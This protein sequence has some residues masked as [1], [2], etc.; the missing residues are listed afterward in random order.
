MPSRLSSRRVIGGV[1]LLAAV[2]ITGGTLAA[3]KV[4]A[5]LPP[6]PVAVEAPAPE[7]EPTPEPV[8][9]APPWSA[10]S[11]VGTGYVALRSV[12]ALAE[13]RGE[14]ALVFVTTDGTVQ[15][16]HAGKAYKV[17]SIGSKSAKSAGA[18]L[19]VGPSGEVV[20]AWRV[21]TSV[22]ASTSADL[23]T[24]S[25]PVVVGTT[26]E[27]GSFHSA[28]WDNGG[29]YVAWVNAA[30]EAAS[31]AMDAPGQAVVARLTGGKWTTST[32]APTVAVV[33]VDK[34]T[35]TYR[36]PKVSGQKFDHV[37]ISAPDGSG[38]IDLGEGYDPAVAVDGDVVAVGYH[39]GGAAWLATSK[40]G[41]KTWERT[42]LDPL[43]QFVDPFIAGG[44]AGA[45][46]ISFPDATA[47]A[48]PRDSSRHR[49]GTWFD[50]K[51][52]HLNGGAEGTTGGQSA[53]IG[54]MP[55]AVYSVAASGDVF[56][57]R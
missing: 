24:W 43:G 23:V 56:V 26:G 8:V 36:T 55:A 48:S 20:V 17:A 38:A 57:V 29:P 4:T 39:I 40:D 32:L 28:A 46:W 44:K 25:A 51:G 7:P 19:A 9:V 42:Q 11:A 54:G 22:Y 37:W 34:G 21:G 53:A 50:G 30:K 31:G 27:G 10:S 6:A 33:A 47:A 14:A 1:A 35:V 41:G 12:P 18:T 49:V 16:A 5:P 13:L 2:S 52:G 3:K 45:V 15:V